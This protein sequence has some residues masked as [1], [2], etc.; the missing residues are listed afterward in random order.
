MDSTEIIDRGRGP[1]L[2]GTRTTVYSLV[3]YFLDE[4]WDDAAIASAGGLSVEQVQVMRAYFAEHRDA[5]LVVHNEI[6]ARNARGNSPEVEA[7]R[8]AARAKLQAVME[9]LRQ[10]RQTESN[11]EG[12]HGRRQH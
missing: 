9:R 7:R 3:P 2:K 11:G 8:P 12:H 10:E 6:E 1:E 4:T 5:V